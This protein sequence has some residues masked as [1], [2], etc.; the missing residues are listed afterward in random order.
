MEKIINNNLIY[1]SATSLQSEI[2]FSY[3]ENE[4]KT[5]F[6]IFKKY[7]IKNVHDITKLKEGINEIFKKNELLKSKFSVIKFNEEDKVFHTIDD[8]SNINVEH[9]SNDDYHE[10][11]RPFDLSKSPLLRVGFVENSILMIDIHRIIA[12]STSIDIL[13]NKLINFCDGDVCLDSTLQVSK[14]LNQNIDNMNSDMNLEFIDNLFNHEY[15]VLNLPKRYNYI[16]LS[17]NNKITEKYSFIVSGEIY[18]TLKNFINCNFNPYSFFISI[19]G[20]TMTKYSE[21]EYIYTSILNN[22]R[23][24]IN[25]DIIGEFDLIQPLLIYINNNIVLNDLINEVNSLLI[26]YDEQKNSLSNKF[27][28]SN[29]LSLNNIFIYKSNNNK[30]KINLNPFIEEINM[31]DNRNDF[32]LFLNK[33]YNFDFIFEVIDDEDKYVF[34]IEYN[35]NLYE[36]KII[37]NIMD[38]YLEII[39]NQENI[40]KNIFDIEYIS[41]REKKRILYDFNRNKIDFGKKFYHVEF[42]KNAKLNPDKCAIVFEDREVTYKILN[43]MSNSLAYYLRNY[44]ITRNEIIPILCERSY[45][46]F[47][48]SLAVMKAGGAFV[49]I[50]PEFPKERIMYMINNVK[51]RIVLNYSQNVND[52]LVSLNQNNSLDVYDLKNHDF[53][54]HRQSELININEIDDIS[55]SFYTSGTTGLPKCVLIS[56]KCLYNSCRYGVERNGKN[57]EHSN[58]LGF[59]PFSF[60]LSFVEL[61]H[62]LITNRMVTLCNN[63][64]YNNPALIGNI[65][66]KYNVDIIISP[67]TRIKFYLNFELF[68]DSLKYIKYFRFGGETVT[69]EFLQ[70]LRQYTGPR[71][72]FCGYGCTELSSLCTFENIDYEE[73]LDR[74]AATL[75]SPINNFPLNVNGKL[76]RKALPE[77]NINDLVVMEDYEAP[78]TPYEKKLCII[79]GKIFNIDIGKIGRNSD[80]FELGGDSLVATKVLGIIEKEFNVRLNIKDVFYYSSIH[81]L[82]QFMEGIIGHYDDNNN[83]NSLFKIEKI[84]KYDSQEFPITSQQL[85]IYI[86]SIKNPNSIIYNNPVAF[87]LKKNTDISKIKDG[88]TKLF[89]KHEILKSKYYEKEINGNIEIYGRIDNECTL[90]FESYTKENAHTFIKPFDISKVPLIRVGFINN[91]VL[92]LDIHHIISDGT[93][94]VII[95]NELNNYYNGNEVK[96]LEVQFKDYAIYINDQKNSAHYAKQIEYYRKMFD[97]EYELLNISKKMDNANISNSKGEINDKK[98]KP[99]GVCRNTINKEISEKINNYTKSNKI[100]KTAFFLSTYGYILSKYSGQNRIYTSMMNT[101][102]NNRYTDEMIGLFVTTLP[103]LLE[104]D[105]GVNILQNIKN[106]MNILMDIYQNSDISFSELLNTLKLKKVNNSFIYQP[107]SIF[108]HNANEVIFED[109]Q[110]LSSNI[111]SRNEDIRNDTKFDI[112]V[113]IHEHL[114]DYDITIEFNNDIYEYELINQILSSYIEIIKNVDQYQNNINTIDYIPKDEIEKI[115]YDFNN[116][117]NKNECEK[118]YHEEFSKKAR[119]YPDRYAIIFNETKIS[120]KELDEMSNSL[121]NYL[122]KNGI[123]RNDIIPIISN[124]SPYYIISILSISKAGGA[125]LPID[126]KLPIECIQFILNEVNPKTILY[127]NTQEIIDKLLILNENYKVYNVQQHD[128]K[129]NINSIGNINEPNDTCY[130]LFTSGTTGKPKGALIS[131]FNIHNYTKEFDESSQFDNISNIIKK[132]KVNNILGITNFSFDASHNETINCLIHGLNLIL[133]DEDIS[134]NISSLS[135]YI[136][137]NNVDFIQTTPSRLN[138]FMENEEFRK[139]LSL[140]KVILLGGE[141]LTIDLCKYIHQYSNCRIYNQYGPTECTIGTTM[142][143]ID[144]VNDENKINIGK[145]Y[146]NYKIYILDEYLKL[147]PV[148]VSGEI[149]IGGYGVG[150]GYLNREDL[151]NEK[152]IENPFNIDDDEHNK[153]IY[154]TGDLGKWTRNGEIEYLGRIDFQVKIHGQRIELGEIESLIN[155]IEKIKHGIVIDKKKENGEKYLVCYYQLNDNNNNSNDNNDNGIK[156]IEGK[157]IRNYLKNKLPHYMIPNYYK[158][159]NE[160]PLSVNGKLNRKELPEINIK[161]IIKEEYIAPETEIEKCICHMYSQLFNINENEI[162]KASDFFELG[163]DSLNAIRLISMIEKEWK[164][165]INI[166]E[167]Y[168]N[169]LIVQLSQYI[170][171]ILNSNNNSK[172]IEIIKKRNSKEFPVTS[173]QLGVYIDSIKNPETIIYNIPESFKLNKNV[174]IEKIKEGFNKIFQNQEIL[175][176]KYYSKEINGKEEIYGFIDDE[177]ILKFEDYTYDNVSSF[178]RPF[179]LSEAPLIRVGFIGNEYLLIDMHHIISD[180]ATMLIIMNELNKY[181]NEGNISELEIQF[182]DYAIDMKEKQDN[183]FYEKQIEFYKEIFNTDYELLNIPQ[184]EKKN[185]CNSNR[186]ENNEIGNC[187]KFIDKIM[188]EKINKY[189]QINKISK[190]ALFLSIY[191]YVLSKYS[192]QEIIYTTIM[193]ANRNNHYFEKMIGM[194]VSTQPILLKYDQSNVSFTDIA[195]NNMKIL[196][197]LYNNH[198]ISFSELVNSLKIK[199]VNNAFI[200]QPMNILD[201]NK[202]GE[203]IFSKENDHKTYTLYEEYGYLLTM[204]YN[205]GKFDSSLIEKI[206][207]SFIEMTQHINIFN[208][209]IQRIEYI[210]KEEKEKIITTFNDNSYEYDCDKLYHIEFSRVAKE[211]GNKI[212]IVY[213]GIKI[214]YSELDKMSN[215]LAHYLRSQN[216]GRGDIIPIICEHSYYYVIAFLGVLKSGA[217]YLPIDPDFPKE[218][219][220]YMISEINAK[221]ILKY[222]SKTEN[223]DKVT[224][225][226]VNIYS[227]D[228]HDYDKN[229]TSINN[230]NESDDLCYIL[231]TSGTTGKPKGTLITH[232]NLINYCLYAQTYN[233]KD[234]YG[235][236]FDNILAFSKFTFDMSLS[237]IQFPLLR[238][239]KIILY[240]EDEYNNPKLLYKLIKLYN[241]YCI[242]TVPS[243]LES[244]ITDEEFLKSLTNL[245]WILFGGEKLNYNLIKIINN[246][247]N[248]AILN[249]YGPTET[250]VCSTIKYYNI[251]I[252]END[253]VTIGKPNCNYKIYILDKMLKPVPIGIVGEIFISGY[254]V[255]KGYLN[256]L[257][258]SKEKFIE[259]PYHSINGKPSIMY[260]TGDLGKWN[261]EGEI[262]CLGRIDFQIKIHGQRIELNEIENTIKEMEEIEYSIVIDQ[263]YKNGDKYL[264]CYYISSNEIENK[265]IIEYLK[266]KLPKYMIPNYYKRIFEIPLLNSGKLDRKALPV[267]NIEDM[268]NEQY[269]A[270]ETNIEKIICKI[271]SKILNISENKVGRTSDFFELGGDRIT[272]EDIMNYSQISHFGKY[273]EELLNSDEIKNKVEIIKRYNSKEFPITSQQLGVYIDSIKHKNNIIYNIPSWYKLNENID[274]EKIKKGFNKIFQNQEILRTKYLE[275]EV[276]GN[277]EIYGFIDDNCKLVF[278]EYNYDNA[279]SFIRPFNLSKAPLIRVG[280]IG[281]EYLLVDIHHIISDGATSLIIMN[282]LNKYYN[283]DVMNELDIQF[284]DYAIHMNEKKNNGHFEKQIEFYKEMF[285]KEYEIPNIPEKYKNIDKMN[286]NEEIISYSNTCEKSIDEEMSKN[287]NEFI[288]NQ[289][290]TKAA[291][292]LTIYGYILSKYCRQELIYTS[293]ISA[294]RNNQYVENMAGM[295][296]ST[297]P[298]L[299]SFENKNITFIDVIKSNMNMMIDVYNNQ[300]ISFSEL[301]ELIKLK[302]VNN[303]FIFQPYI[304]SS[305]KNE[306]NIFNNNDN[307]MNLFTY[308]SNDN[309]QNNSKFD[310]SFTVN[311]QQKNY[312][313]LIE[314]NPNEYELKT[315]ENILNSINEVIKNINYNYEQNINEI[316]Y[317]PKEEK[318]KIINKFNSNINTFGCDK[319]YHEEFCKIANKYPKRCAIVFNDMKI[320]YKELDEMSNSLEHYLRENGIQRNDIIPIISNRSPYYIISI[321]AISKAGG[322]FLPIDPKLPIDRIQFILE[323]VQPKIILYENSKIEFEKITQYK[324]IIYDLKHHN[325]ELKRDRIININSSNDICYVLYTSGT[326]GKPKG[327]LINHFNIYNYLKTFN[328]KNEMETLCLDEL[329]KKNHINN[330]LAITNFSFDISHNEITYCLIHGLTSILIDENVSE[331][332]SLLSQY[333]MENKVDL[334]N[335]TP[336]R[337][338]LFMENEMFRQSLKIIK[339]I[340]FIGEELPLSLCKNIHQYSEYNYLKLV[341]IGVEG[342]IFIGGYGVGRGYLNR[343]E[344]TKEK[345]INNPF[346]FDDDEHNG[347]MYRTGDLGKWTSYGEIEYLGRMDFQVKIHGHRIE[348]EEIENIIKDIDGIE[349]CVVIDKEKENKD[350][351]LVCYYISNKEIDGKIIRSSL[352]SKLPIYMIPNYYI[353]ISEFPLSMS[354][355]LNRKALPVPTIKDI[356]KKEYEAPKTDTEKS[357][358]KIYSEIFNVPYNEIGRTSDFY[359]LGGDSL[360]AIRIIAY[361]KT[362]FKIKIYMKDIMNNSE[363]HLISSLIDE[364]LENNDKRYQIEFIEKYNSDEYPTSYILPP[365]LDLKNIE[366]NENKEINI[367]TYKN[368]KY[369]I[370]FYYK[371]KCPIDINK[372][373]NSFNILINRHEVLK[374]K[375]IVKNINGENK[376]FGRIIK[377]AKIEIEHYTKDN[378]MELEKPI[379]LTKD[380]LIKVAIIEN[381]ILVIKTSHLICDG[382]SYGILINELFKIYND[383]I[384]EDLPIQYSDYA[385]HQYKKIS[386]EDYTEQIEYYSSIFDEPYTNIKLPTINN[387]NNK[388]NNKKHNIVTIKTDTEVY[389]NVNRIIKENNI[390]KTTFFLTI[391]CLVMSIYSGQKNI[392]V[393]MINSNRKNTYTEMLIGLFMKLTPILVKMENVNLIDF[394]NKYKNILLTL[395]SYD[396]PDSIL[397]EKLNFSKCHSQFK[398][399]PYEL[400][401]K[402]DFSY[403]EYI[404]RFDVYKMFNKELNEIDFGDVNNLSFCV[405]ERENYYD[406]SFSYRKDVYEET[407]L[408]NIIYSFIDIIKNE[409]YLNK[410]LDYIIESIKIKNNNNNLCNNMN[411]INCMPSYNKE[412]AISHNDEQ[413]NNLKIKNENETDEFEIS[414]NN[415]NKTEEFEISNNNESKT[416]EFEISNNNEN[417][418]EKSKVSNNKKNSKYF[419]IQQGDSMISLNNF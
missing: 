355:K 197:E 76:N 15:N 393:E 227:L 194:F 1:Y 290:I 388:D 262:E 97:C 39:K 28:N 217:A 176:T 411:L 23:N 196:M 52:I 369:I 25:K 270:P 208:E 171:K 386:K 364:I 17:G 166:K 365:T 374:T 120:Y 202:S 226:N 13:I 53:K 264:I 115:I 187:I 404:D 257:E 216:I 381:D 222:I 19:Y 350:K 164:I 244:Y 254:G 300:D 258:L 35:N 108:H 93:T 138:L 70:N 147:V 136:I 407:L 323:E 416:K 351:Y 292:F 105:D 157:D 121:G 325:Y 307:S 89:N 174:N 163:G 409:D 189:T 212:A 103:L 394:L 114:D 332:I 235:D 54:N 200:F 339:S 18:E 256:Q 96:E 203:S 296:I 297:L 309:M 230:I 7:N 315:I 368:S 284:S 408:K 55:C 68:R 231:F 45:Y 155:E 250:T 268:I 279:S 88:F 259:C 378:F 150:K 354:G 46:F 224:F 66:K 348:L 271:Y 101:N 142:K 123:Q 253:N 77:P 40:Y 33:L 172:N 83:R 113:S 41:P 62:P 370:L 116:D 186:K 31:Y 291:F 153:I 207:N 9:Y 236:G 335:T 79:F 396:I 106:N 112:T 137:K 398:F 228:H 51:A 352:K 417:K 406:I 412:N 382:Y 29:L 178:I 149:F 312:S 132:E 159:I 61:F 267:P 318:E 299:L 334:I 263:K 232:N 32:H 248:S 122:R 92:L 274:I 102:R 80:F 261:E 34:T 73:I 357:I 238:G 75:G 389:N 260:R 37:K 134:N 269:E 252:K 14:Y 285:S 72:Y 242:Y 94:M 90:I 4:D 50:S 2:Y 272:I 336:T 266:E 375:F 99:I 327:A 343:D 179:K 82:G 30:S 201:N 22:R 10:F 24:S 278:E 340:I 3:F 117:T 405:A 419:A 384:L 383:E 87:R 277:I 295:F 173:Q 276:N 11:I 67:P 308:E 43:E 69:L 410:S 316:E 78:K 139:C 56:H 167:I 345:F 49:F 414:N 367:D 391:Y 110:D 379:D 380:L 326:T 362:T 314:F 211:N 237:E 303:T 21:Q 64:E 255:G 349:Q 392:Y 399:D 401:S 390:S 188:N 356:V 182:S 47:V 63:N 100:S 148:G 210:P 301:T 359:E 192:G 71:E 344:L 154:R 319:L 397:S 233:G 240:N 331:N 304:P 220:E 91:E 191:G 204:E 129:L 229:I 20:L 403:L 293:I 81:D 213:N 283:D 16:K 209:S 135:K 353:R 395:F 199:I 219:I 333:I 118:L 177:C 387:N 161:D 38:S 131:H 162:G 107:K 247:C 84:E 358:C 418:N 5:K 342:E 156:E 385:I 329:M 205:K 273:I 95:Q 372:L 145:P 65:I 298:I 26:Q 85:G 265:K 190:S 288:K 366:N 6:N 402:D 215:S 141:A 109:Y 111:E 347:I 57:F 289:G 195:K 124:R 12:D 328:R 86:D 415:K 280:F 338:K 175:R 130:V 275:K 160:I 310:I 152:F 180:G 221:F 133:V 246:N 317:I 371:I 243:R 36:N 286:Q 8:N 169:S 287:I 361:I 251:K 128:Y 44:G 373:A 241:V 60:V 330:I 239:C 413:K 181:Y 74:N 376:V 341:P 140:I 144:E 302:K 183:G 306:T 158:K 119:L 127:N 170:E 346:N 198:D 214:S 281:N 168:E 27:K 225:K 249:G 193:N 294:N 223:N 59:T 320:N 363:V 245:K 377:D 143:L 282:E 185:E 165:K 58:M 125:F 337:F 98:R 324:S 360:N 400:N 322:A 234:I 321:L 126:P 305:N 146:C 184:K 218:R 206:M 313:I 42:S 48:A 151:T 104:Y 311:E